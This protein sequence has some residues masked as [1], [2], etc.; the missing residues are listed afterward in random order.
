MKFQS[1]NRKIDLIHPPE[2]IG[3]CLPPI[4]GLVSG[5]EF[6]T[7]VPFWK[8]GG[9]LQPVPSYLDSSSLHCGGQRLGQRVVQLICR[10]DSTFSRSFRE[11]PVFRP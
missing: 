9:G 11:L 10:I 4:G 6:M 7:K 2:G 5:L 3:P 8:Y 1:I